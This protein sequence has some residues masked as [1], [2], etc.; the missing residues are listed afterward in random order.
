MSQIAS[1]YYI[2]FTVYFVQVYV[3][4]C[5]FYI[6]VSISHCCYKINVKYFL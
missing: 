4:D 3:K 5:H 2:A 1:Q 6:L